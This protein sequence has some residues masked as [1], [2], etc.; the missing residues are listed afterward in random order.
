MKFKK[1]NI[2]FNI[3][4]FLSLT[5]TITGQEREMVFE[6][7]QGLSNPM[8]TGIMQDTKGFLWVTTWGGLNRFDGYKFKIY[9]SVIGDSLS[10]HSNGIL[11]IA[12]DCKGRIW[13]ATNFGLNL[14]DRKTDQFIRISANNGDKYAIAGNDLN[15]ILID[16]K[17]TLWV[18]TNFNGI[19]TLNINND[20]DF[21]KVKPRFKQYKHNDKDPTSICSNYVRSFF[22]D[23]LGHIWLNVNANLIDR[24]NSQKDNFEHYTLNIPDKDK[25]NTIADLLYEDIDGTFWLGTKGAGLIIWN[26]KNNTFTQY[27][28]QHGRNSLSGNFVRHVRRDNNGIYWIS[29]DGGGISLFD[30]KNG[31]FDYCKYETTNPN[32]LGSNAVYSTL[33]DRSGVTWAATFNAGINKINDNTKFKLYRPNPVDK[34]SLNNKSVLALMEDENG[35]LWIGTDGGGLNFLDRKTDKFKYFKHDP[36]NPS[37]VS[38]NAIICLTEDYDGKIWIGTYAGGINCFDRKTNKF[39]R[40]T[41]DANDPYS[42]SNND[43]WS[44]LED[45]KHNLWI[46]TLAGTLNLYDRNADRFYH[47]KHDPADPGSFIESYTTQIYEDSRH[48]LWLATSNGLEMTKLDD[49]NFSN[50]PPKLKFSHYTHQEK[51]NSI[52]ESNV[53]CICEDHE[54]NMWFG[55]EEGGLNKLDMKTNTFYTFSERDGIEEKTIREIVEDNKYNL[56]ISTVNGIWKYNPRTKGFK[57]FDV[58]DGLQDQIFSRAY[59][60]A[61]N[62]LLYFGGV[63]GFNIIDPDNIKINSVPPKLAITELLIFNKPVRVG[64]K[65]SGRIVLTQSIEET[66]EIRLSYNMNLVAFEFASLDYK[67]PKR[68]MYAYKLEGFDKQWFYTDANNRIATYTNLDPGKYIFRVKASNNDDIWNEKGIVLKVIILPPWWKTVWFRFVLLVTILLSVYA[69]FYLRVAFYKKKQN[70]L[71][72]L[73]NERTQEISKANDI[74]IERQT[75]IEKYADELRSHTQNLR[76]ANDLLL[77]K[78]KLIEKQAEQLQKTNQQLSILNSTKDRFFSIIAHDLRN[79]FHAVGGFAEILIRDYKKLPPEK[80]ERFL[81]I[82]HS[83]SISGNNL[84]ENLLQWSRSQTGRIAYD[85]LKIRLFAI[86]EEVLNL[87][88]GDIHKKNIEVNQLI[89]PNIFVLADEN[90][91]KTIFRNLI[92]NAVKFSHEQGIIT[93]QSKFTDSQ[94]EITVTDTGVGISAENLPLLFRID[95]SVSTQ[96]TANESGT[97]LGLILCKEFIEKHHGRIWV[98]SETDRGSAFTFTLPSA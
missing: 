19:C 10:L 33:E 4:V 65:I 96:G 81:N 11:G 59:L 38:S 47:Y 22:E 83:S 52:S 3:L 61:K 97:G 41:N 62:G 16:S 92:S 89:D 21:M 46:G 56:W 50:H 95:T 17:G 36:D 93:L 73:V 82:I 70:E 69:V 5:Y 45:S 58:T 30:K 86:A 60:K 91:I 55:T 20:T 24:Y 87:L 6:K 88:E 74:L 66:E 90:M 80:I 53:S 42:L 29:T 39:K 26:R 49:Y 68:N 31:H 37:S 72:V 15:A 94:V 77:E 44:L 13:I 75:R 64:Q 9:K 67:N 63:N 35:N 27:K 40:Y 71:A 8:T 1:V 7:I 79:P 43:V 85:P 98:K 51:I 84:L 48:Y 32:S 34:N 18:A 25:A 57:K 76:E 54:G 14:Y 78:Q 12:E 23:K 2:V 28:Y